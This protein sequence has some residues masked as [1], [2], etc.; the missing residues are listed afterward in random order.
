[1]SYKNPRP[2]PGTPYSN[3]CSVFDM[4]ETLGNVMESQSATAVTY[5]GVVIKTMSQIERDA[6]AVLESLGIPVNYPIPNWASN[7]LINTFQAYRSPDGDLIFPKADL[8][9]TTASTYP[10]DIDKWGL[11]QGIG[12]VDGI[13]NEPIKQPT[14]IANGTAT[15]FS[16]PGTVIYEDA[17][18]YVY[19][20]GLRQFNYTVPSSGLIRFDSPPPANAKVDIVLYVP[21]TIDTDRS[22]KAINSTTPFS[23]DRKLQE[24]ATLQEYGATGNAGEDATTPFLDAC[25]NNEHVIIRDGV[26]HVGSLAN[27]TA[28]SKV[29]K[30]EIINAT[31]WLEDGIC[32]IDIAG[33]SFVID[34][35]ANGEIHGGLRKTQVA[36]DTAIGETIISCDDTSDIKV[37]DNIATSWQFVGAQGGSKWTNSIREPGDEFNIVESKTS[38]SITVKFPVGAAGTNT[39]FPL[40]KNMWLGNARFDRPGLRFIGPGMVTILGGRIREARSGY[41]LSAECDSPL[42]LTVNVHDTQFSGQFLDAFAIRGYSS[43]NQYGGSIIGCY[44]LAKQAFF[45]RQ[46]E[47]HD[48]TLNNVFMEK[49]NNDLDFY[50]SGDGGGKMG[51]VVLN[52]CELSGKWTVAPELGQVNSINGQT[53]SQAYPQAQNG[54]H[55]WAFN[56]MVPTP[57]SV[58]AEVVGIR[59]T[60]CVFKY[61]KRA[62][63]GTTYNR[64]NRDYS[65]DHIELIDCDYIE[66]APIYITITPGKTSGIGSRRLT[67]P[68]IKRSPLAGNAH[69]IVYDDSGDWHVSGT[70]KYNPN[71]GAL[72]N[73][74]LRYNTS[75]DHLLVKGAGVLK[76]AGAGEFISI[77]QL[78]VDQATVFPEA[79]IDTESGCFIK[80]K[81]GGAFSGD[82]PY[83]VSNALFGNNIAY[84]SIPANSTDWVDICTTGTSAN[85]AYFKLVISGIR[86]Y[87]SSYGVMGEVSAVLGSA[88][89]PINVATNDYTSVMNTNAAYWSGKVV[90]AGFTAADGRFE[91]RV[92][93]GVLQIR[94]TVALSGGEVPMMIMVLGGRRN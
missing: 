68:N 24:T 43:Y 14:Q 69:P 90:T 48:V 59:A 91:L 50:L 10:A 83:G 46:F 26:F 9:F 38:N 67:N 15:D 58:V 44:D 56:E 6:K 88:A 84:V 71:G 16:A 11:M 3:P 79:Q 5:N 1:M 51:G 78:T 42:G 87:A 30:I 77:A 70:C 45:L 13:A 64:N 53:L 34:L 31:L 76:F 82:I 4:T 32:D 81:N 21:V 49:G 74:T 40:W 20:D 28:D 55:V 37:G 92:D 23:V 33:K 8:P 35:R 2:S 19:V 47:G 54:L 22:Y 72:S 7:T 52:N 36:A 39:T 94:N 27:V 86:D 29:S 75:F 80:R 12:D 85:D 18:Y 17:S 61:Y 65:V 57:P 93:S 25:R 63:A 66:T 89:T 60:D 73:S 62:V 41:Y